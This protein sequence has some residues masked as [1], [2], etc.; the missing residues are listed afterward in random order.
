MP[1]LRS[2]HAT[3]RH[4]LACHNTVSS[5]ILSTYSYCTLVSC[6]QGI[7]FRFK[8]Y[9]QAKQRDRTKIRA[10]CIN[11]RSRWPI[12]ASLQSSV[13]F[14]CSSG[15]G[16]KLSNTINR[17]ASSGSQCGG[18]SCRIRS[19]RTDSS[20]SNTSVSI[21][22][23]RR[24]MST[25]LTLACKVE[26]RREI[27]AV[28]HSGAFLPQLVKEGVH[29]GFHRAQACAG[30]VFQEFRHQVNSLGCRAWPEDLSHK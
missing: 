14:S 22:Q 7:A 13:I 16:T 20:A 4:P 28:G 12:T 6:V 9:R 2:I 8:I 23:R 15:M 30:R 10:R 29:H 27:L 21:P 18:T 1:S 26:Q 24:T 5:H 3:C 25:P 11:T 17:K 19:G